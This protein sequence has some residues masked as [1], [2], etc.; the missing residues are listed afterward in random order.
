MNFTL[1]AIL[2][3]GDYV[4]FT[5]FIGSMAMLAATVFFFLEMGNV[6]GKWRTSMLISGLI[7]FIAAV[8]YFYMR[9]FWA[10]THTSPT[11]FRYIDWILT[12]PLMCVEFY[13]IL[14]AFGAKMD[15]LWKMIVYS[16]WMLIFGY[17]GETVYRDSSAIWGAI[18]TLGYVGIFYEVWFGS[19]KKLSQGSNDPHLQKAFNTLAWFILVGWAIYPIGYMA[20]PGGL[21]SGVLPLESLDI[22]YNIG[23]AINKI[24]FGLVIYSLAISSGKK[25]EA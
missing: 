7:T 14:K 2:Q 5:F 25:A 20:I 15:L 4:G 16:L 19:A 21:L 11:E 17:L 1:N 6:Q 23:D 8:H 22:I 9:D 3:S 24:G 12:V 13:L 10:E 18:S